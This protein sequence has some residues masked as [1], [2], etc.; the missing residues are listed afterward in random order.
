MPRLSDPSEVVDFPSDW[1]PFKLPNI[2]VLTHKEAS[3]SL[4][5]HAGR[6]AV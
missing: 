5:H 2:R 4:D 6:L 1:L 3:Q